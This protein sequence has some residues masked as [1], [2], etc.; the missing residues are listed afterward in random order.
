MAADALS[1]GSA[2]H[3]VDAKCVERVVDALAL[4]TVCMAHTETVAWEDRQ[5]AMDLGVDLEGGTIDQ[6]LLA[7]AGGSAPGL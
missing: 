1:A 5:T 3:E 4:A 6:F 2:L 7:C